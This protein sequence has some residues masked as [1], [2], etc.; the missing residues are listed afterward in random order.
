VVYSL[1]PDGLLRP[2]FCGW[3]RVA[4][5]PRHPC[6]LAQYKEPVMQ[7][8]HSLFVAALLIGSLL[9]G[10]LVATAMA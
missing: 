4:Q 2:F 3:R 5:R 9:L 8:L 10:M 7:L 1:V 6:V